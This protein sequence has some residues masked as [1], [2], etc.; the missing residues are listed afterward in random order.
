MSV[1]Y[2]LKKGFKIANKYKVIE[3]LGS[4]YEGEVYKIVEISTGIHS[5]AKLF[6]SNRNDKN[7]TAKNYALK[8]HSLR[9]CDIILKYYTQEQLVFNEKK[10]TVFIYEY[11]DGTLLINYL[12]SQ[13]KKKLSIFKAVHLLYTILEGLELIHHYGFVHGDL[14]EENII[15][16]RI[17]LSYELKFLDFFTATGTKKQKEFQDMIDAIKI[18]YNS[19]GGAKAYK[20]HPKQVKEICC[21]LKKT[22]IQKKFKSISDLKLYLENQEW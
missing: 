6:F 4:G 1:K 19:L 13:P 17:G 9:D 14:H 18:F 16:R 20:H 7:K 12:K 11:V 8:L 2:N 15:V 3:H 5:A 21:G 22:L 10:I